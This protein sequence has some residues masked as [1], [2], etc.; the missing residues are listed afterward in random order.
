MAKREQKTRIPQGL[1]D[2][3]VT[4]YVR[5]ELLTFR[6]VAVGTAYLTYICQRHSGVVM[7]DSDMKVLMQR[8][9]SRQLVAF[10]G[11]WVITQTGM[12]TLP[13]KWVDD[14]LVAQRDHATKAGRRRRKAA[15]NGPGML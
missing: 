9:E 11:G 7:N 3:A 12:R 10:D 13:L 14:D 8:L 2:L 4:P 1:L 15:Q 6:P 5:T